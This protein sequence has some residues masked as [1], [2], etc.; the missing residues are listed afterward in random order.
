MLCM[1]RRLG[2]LMAAVIILL[3]VHLFAFE[4]SHRECE[5]KVD[6]QFQPTFRKIAQPLGN[7]VYSNTF[8]AK[9]VDPQHGRVFTA[10]CDTSFGLARSLTASQ[11]RKMAEWSL[12]E[13]SK[14]IGLKASRVFWEQQGDQ[15]TLRMIGRR[16]IIEAGKRLNA[17]FQARMYLGQRSSMMVAVGEPASISPSAEME[18]FLNGSVQMAR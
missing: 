13:W 2:F 16:N 5:F 15:I 10:N 9:A 6:F 7:G 8:M 17:A 12:N 11:K 1:A 4:F 14:M 3:P 18:R